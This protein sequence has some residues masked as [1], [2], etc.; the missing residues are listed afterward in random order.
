[1]DRLR[2]LAVRDD[3]RA[4]VAAA[5]GA[6]A[7]ALSLRKL[8]RERARRER[9][10]GLRKLELL[11]SE[12]GAV[13]LM[14]PSTSTVTFFAGDPVAAAAALASRVA[15]V[16]AL[17]PWLASVLDYDDAGAL[18]CFYPATVDAPLFRV[19]DAPLARTTPYGAAVAAVDAAL[20]A[21][22]EACAGTGAPL[23]RVSL[24][25]DRDDPTGRFA[26]VVSASHVLVDGHGFY[27][28]HN[29][30]SADAPLRALSPER[31]FDVPAK[32]RAA[33]GGEPSLM[34][35]CPPGFLARFV[36]GQ[37][38]AALFPRTV[39][40]GFYVD[41]AWLA[42]QKQ[43]TRL[44]FVSTNDCVV[45][46][47]LNC[48]QP[49]CALMAVNFR[50]KL[51]DFE[52][53]DL[54]GNYEDLVTYTRGSYETPDLIRRSVAGPLYKRAGG[55]AP[56]SN[57]EHLGATYGA[58]TNWSTF[59]RPLDLGRGAAQ[60]L[61][62]PLFDWPKACPACVFGSLVLFRPSAGRVAAMVAGTRALVD[63]V[64]ACGAAGAPLDAALA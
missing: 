30:L 13:L 4:A 60:D 16:A 50:G 33:A 64:L 41:G 19:V 29:M 12:T 7:V 14:S 8:R 28:V 43:R 21:T 49:D 51:E 26:V 48:L 6:G 15:D 2:K 55:R 57:V 47:F 46:A 20:V 18:A 1:M 56:P 59:A 34:A 36:F 54:A 35:A 32:M 9:L 45:S 44:P 39:F 40:A 27:A 22:G 63:A 23:F 38:W 37:V 25:P 3:W 61:H 17:N 62:L 11:P 52:G 58:V 31:R 24:V 5:L 42:A 10:A 53:E